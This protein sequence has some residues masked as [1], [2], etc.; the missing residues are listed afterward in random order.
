MSSRLQ[1]HFHC[2]AISRYVAIIRNSRTHLSSR[3]TTRIG[4]RIQPQFGKNV[5][6]GG[7]SVE[8]IALTSVEEFLNSGLAAIR[9]RKTTCRASDARGGGKSPCRGDTFSRVGR[10]C[11]GS[12]RVPSGTR[13]KKSLT[14]KLQ[15]VQLDQLRLLTESKKWRGVWNWRPADGEYSKET[16]VQNGIGANRGPGGQSNWKEGFQDCPSAAL[17]WRIIRATKESTPS[18]TSCA[19]RLVACG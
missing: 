4:S 9:R 5:Y 8:H 3:F 7:R 16:K 15:A 1:T 10:V 17:L 2:G 6:H 12:V 13:F 14:D 18:A 11:A 19:T